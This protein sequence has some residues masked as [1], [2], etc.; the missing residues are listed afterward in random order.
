[1]SGTGIVG[2]GMVSISH[3]MGGGMALRDT[4][5]SQPIPMGALTSALLHL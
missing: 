3:D 1:M 2:D 4:G 5:I